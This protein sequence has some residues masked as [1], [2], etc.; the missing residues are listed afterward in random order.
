[1]SWLPKIT[2]KTYLVIGL[3][4]VIL[5]AIISLAGYNLLILEPAG[6]AYNSRLQ[7]AISRLRAAC[8]SLSA[9]T[10][11]RLLAPDR[12][13]SEQVADIKKLDTQVNDLR[14]E[15]DRFAAASNTIG[16]YFN[17]YISATYQ[18]SLVLKAHSSSTTSQIQEVLD[19][20][21][22]LLSF[23]L[24]YYRIRQHLTDERKTAKP[25]RFS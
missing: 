25:P 14:K 8:D 20:Y 10:E 22:R 18:K 4:V 17:T 2:K 3:A 13:T 11:V 15:V 1:M 24:D 23:L 6:T 21:D 5:L 19:E 16:S 9:A 7:A 12:S